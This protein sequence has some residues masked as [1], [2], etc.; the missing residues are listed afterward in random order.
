MIKIDKVRTYGFEEAVRG[1]RNSFA[2]WDKSDSKRCLLENEP[3]FMLGENDFELMKKLGRN[4]GSHAKYRRMIVVYADITAPL[5]WWKEFD[6][7][8]VGTV[9][10]S[11]SSMHSIEDKEFSKDDF[12]FEH[13]GVAEMS[14]LEREKGGSCKYEDW[15]TVY[16]ES[17]IPMLNKA[18]T[19]Y[20]KAKENAKAGKELPYNVSS[21]GEFQKGLWWQMIQL[22]PTSYN[23][24]R[25]VMMNYAGVLRV[26]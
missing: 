13:I 16:A 1:M 21:W 15:R 18:R 12:S 9:A 2:S 5:Y 8:K 26:D 22:L 11:T 4:G 17:L 24:L 10:L 6:T 7:Y 23:Q 14:K 3:V 19:G 20:L 25:T